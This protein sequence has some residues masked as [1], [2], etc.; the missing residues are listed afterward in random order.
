MRNGL[1]SLIWAVVLAGLPVARAQ[2]A[3]PAATAPAA[4]S[5]A[6][7]PFVL[8]KETTFYTGPLRPDGTVDYVEAINE[9]LSRGVTPEDNAAIPLLDAVQAGK[10]EQAAH[11][12][13]IR[14][15]LGMPAAPLQALAAVPAGLP[16]GFDATLNGPW[17]AE[18]A[19]AVAKWLEAQAP[20]LDR[21]LEA[22]RRTRYYLPLVR[23]NTRDT[24]VEVLLPHLNEMRGLANALKSRAMLALGREDM[25]AFRRDVTA[26]LRVARL[27]S[28]GPTLIERLVAIGC[29]AMALDLIQVA[30][31]G[32]WLSAADVERFLADL[33]A[34]PAGRV[35]EVFELG[36]RTFML[37]FLQI[38]AV[39]GPAEA[40]KMFRAMAGG[41]GKQNA[42]EENV[43]MPPVDPA[44]KDWNAA[45]RKANGWYDRHAD[46]GKLPTWRERSIASAAIAKDLDAVRR[47]LE[48][49]RGVFAPIEDR[50]LAIALPATTRAYQVEAKLERDRIMTEIVLAL[51]LFRTKT[52]EYPATL[53][54][55]TP[56]YFKAEPI[57]PLTDE[58]PDYR[59][60]AGGYELR[61]FGE[62]RRED[63]GPKGDDKVLRAER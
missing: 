22:S 17:T 24:I 46:A 55:L 23:E 37:E 5:A 33:R 10:A 51:S 35:Y 61:S 54:E 38:A 27:T 52:G 16:D 14:A 28:G 8:S 42:A 39:H 26:I 12:T 15:K 31:T 2:E 11:Y 50:M 43:P 30:A 45:L 48:G 53:K 20:R 21:V 4:R 34:T 13:K 41:G 32:G 60:E 62:N 44:A 29:E 7:R 9:R 57:D 25:E 49:W 6:T 63:R 36:E 19:P 3:K 40:S 58:P 1:F 18:K 59:P 56:A 47:R